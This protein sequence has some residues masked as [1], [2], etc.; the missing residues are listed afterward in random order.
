MRGDQFIPANVTEMTLTTLL[1][2]FW[3]LQDSIVQDSEDASGQSSG[4]K[5]T[6]TTKVSG[7]LLE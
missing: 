4:K 6:Q 3:S 1:E 2:E 7:Q 5:T